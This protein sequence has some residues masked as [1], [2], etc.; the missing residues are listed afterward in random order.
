VALTDA[1][2]FDKD[3]RPEEEKRRV[4]D[5]V[6]IPEAVCYEANEGDRNLAMGVGSE[7]SKVESDALAE[8][9]G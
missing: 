6:G 1:P 9:R 5:G 4:D 2:V 8:L 7:K 3:N